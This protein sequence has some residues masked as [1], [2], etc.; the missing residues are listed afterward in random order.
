MPYTRHGHY[1]E[2][3]PLKEKPDL[4]AR[5]GGPALCLECSMERGSV[6]REDLPPHRFESPNPPGTLADPCS[7]CGMYVAHVLHREHRTPSPKPPGEGWVPFG[8]NEGGSGRLEFSP[9]GDGGLPDWERPVRMMQVQES[10]YLRCMA[11]FALLQDLDRCEHGRHSIDA[12]LDCQAAGTATPDG[13]SHGN[14][15]LRPGAVFGYGVRGVRIAPPDPGSVDFF[16]PAKWY[17]P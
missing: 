14:P 4:V 9:L 16:D 2:N 17:Q 11:A 8:T 15:H 1:V 13:R 3:G 5:C 7:I 6:P 10:V 12:C